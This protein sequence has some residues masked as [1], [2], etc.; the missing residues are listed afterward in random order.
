MATFTPDRLRNVALLGHTGSGK[1]TLGE[2]LLFATGAISRMGRVEDGNTVA[3][4]EPEAVKRRGSVQLALLPCF[5]KEHKI[6]FIDTPG[7]FDFTGEVISAL[8]AVDAVVLC[9]SA[10]AGVEVITEQMWERVQEQHLPCLIVITKMDRENAD[11]SRCLASI[12]QTFGRQCV[13]Y[14]IPIGAAQTFSGIVPLLPL[15]ESIPAEVK[16]QV[17][18]ARERLVEAIAETDDALATKYLEGEVIAD[19]DL[20]HAL[21]AGVVQG[22]VVP[23]LVT[24]ALQGKGVPQ[25]LD[26]VLALLPSPAESPPVEATNPATGQKEALRTDPSGPLAALVFKTTADPYVGKLSLFRVVSGTFTPGEVF[27]ATKGQTERVGQ[28][29]LL[30]GKT[31]EAV[32]SLMAGDIGAV[33]KLQAT[34]TGDTLC[35]RDHPLVVPGLSFPEPLYSLAVYPKTK[36]DLDKLGPALARLV[37]EDPSLRFTR[38]PGTGEALLQGLGDAHLDV[39]LQR[40]QRKFGVGLVVQTPKVPYKET[41][42][43]RADRVESRYKKQTGGHGHYAHIVVRIEPLPRGSGLEFAE[44]VV[45]GVVPKEFIPAVEKGVKRAAAEGVVA[46]YPVTDVRVVL[47]DGS[48]HPVDSASGDFEIAGYEGLRKGVLQANP[49]LLEP[50][51]RLEVT[52]PDQFSGDVI[53]D[54]NGKRGRILGMTPLGNGKTQIDAL[55]P[56]VEVQ[57]YVLDLRSLTQGRGTFRMT[58]DH[59]EELPPHLA[60]KVIEQVK[61]A[62]AEGGGR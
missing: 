27:N 33:T 38:E 7:Y 50:I 41:V 57:R 61:Q 8:R 54:L 9:V 2:A 59:Y 53:G 32:P 20:Q 26:A 51:M 34:S 12:Q 42:S 5:W 60:Q 45:G 40:A 23:V 14:Q 52:V 18:Q 47:F 46:G 28:V 13:A 48:S 24:S 3:D 6:T 58:F 55:V 29:F 30:R 17:E 16:A 21:R 49:V 25:L 15:P 19:Q 43:A 22:K 36:A 56:L 37:E 62:R 39:A 4:Y 44:E 10:N 1:T 11:F 35:N 31:Q